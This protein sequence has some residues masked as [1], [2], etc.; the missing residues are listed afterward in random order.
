MKALLRSGMAALMLAVVPA[1]LPQAG[2][3]AIGGVGGMYYLPIVSIKEKRWESV[4]RQQYDFS[5]GA[6][7]VA[8]LLSH[9]YNRSTPEAEV[10]KAM[11]ETGD[12][13]LIRSRGFSMLD[14]K[15]YLEELGYHVD[16]FRVDL[17]RVQN[18]GVPAV[19]IITTNG[20][21]HFVV[22]KGLDENR[23]LVGD[24]AFGTTVV[25][26][27]KFEKMW[28]GTMLAVRDQPQEARKQFNKAN[29]WAV[30]LPAPIGNGVS[31]GSVAAFTRELPGM[32]DF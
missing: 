12:Q 25:E 24:P 6:A 32:E 31:R 7:A 19:A 17:A 13:K 9:H 11:F 21:R 27:G 18:I 28:D 3:V 8:T 2:E 23:V 5:C 30:R 15:R 20:Y 29:D 22:V 14:M 26:R 4:V 16:G 10:F 1:A